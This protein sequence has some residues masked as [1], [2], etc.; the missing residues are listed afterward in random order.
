VTRVRDRVAERPQQVR[1][2]LA[3]ADAR[4]LRPTLL[5]AARRSGDVRQIARSRR[6]GDIHDRRAVV[7]VDARER[8]SRLAAVVADVRDE[9][10]ALLVDRR[11]VRRAPLQIVVADQLH[12]AGFGAV[13]A[14]RLRRRGPCDE[15][16]QHEAEENHRKT[17]WQGSHDRLLSA[18]AVVSPG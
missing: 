18:C 10:R 13:T 4:H 7:F 6:V 12:V 11:L 3:I 15:R 14:R 5:A 17:S 8:V 9:A 2:A 1:L 16:C